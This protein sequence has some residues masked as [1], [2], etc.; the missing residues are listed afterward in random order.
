MSGCIIAG[1]DAIGAKTYSRCSTVEKSNKEQVKDGV[2]IYWPKI[3]A[4]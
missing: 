1:A 3:L 4:S 2:D